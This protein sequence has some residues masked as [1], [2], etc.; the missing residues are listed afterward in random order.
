MWCTF[1]Y[2]DLAFSRRFSLFSI[3]HPQLNAVHPFLTNI[4]NNRKYTSANVCLNLL[5]VL[6][7]A[8]T[9]RHISLRIKSC[10]ELKV[11]TTAAV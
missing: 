4:A 3:N 9:D 11:F 8:S 10:D 7:Y 1:S 2:V 6:H 5:A